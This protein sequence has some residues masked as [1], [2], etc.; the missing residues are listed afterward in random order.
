[1]KTLLWLD[2][3]RDPSH[4]YLHIVQH[5]GDE[6]LGKNKIVWVR[7]SDEFK[8]YIESNP[9][10]DDIALDHDL[11][12]LIMNGY[13]LIKYLA[14]YCLENNIKMPNVISQSGNP[15]GKKAIMDYY[16]FCKEKMNL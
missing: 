12:E 3:M 5:F 8:D 9:M 15:I 14:K 4:Y 16:Q 7:D 11:G 10:P 13:E 1:M 6:Y 2:D